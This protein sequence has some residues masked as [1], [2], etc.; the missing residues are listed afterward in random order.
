MKGILGLWGW[1]C[2]WGTG[3]GIGAGGKR[4]MRSTNG[5]HGRLNKSR[6]RAFRAHDDRVVLPEM[7]SRKK[8]DKL[9]GIRTLSAGTSGSCFKGATPFSSPW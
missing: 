7:G 2:G 1:N 3:I 5:N 4:S 8:N 6:R 9:Q